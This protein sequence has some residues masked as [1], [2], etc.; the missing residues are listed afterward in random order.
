[1]AAA[2]AWGEAGSAA[3]AARG[4]VASEWVRAAVELVWAGALG[5]LAALP[6]W[7]LWEN[8]VGLLQEV[9]A[10]P[11]GRVHSGDWVGVAARARGYSLPAVHQC[12]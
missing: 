5:L 11:A 7:D 8:R 9:G 3:P 1:M 4:A 10:S 2:L 6:D 12:W